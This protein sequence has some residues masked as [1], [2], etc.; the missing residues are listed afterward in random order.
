MN[1]MNEALAKRNFSAVQEYAILTR[2]M[3]RENNAKMVGMEGS[4]KTLQ[5]QIVG[6]QAQVSNL[7]AKVLGGGA[8]Q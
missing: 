5:D 2:E 8:T 7:Q 1:N 3:Q 4:I 6:L